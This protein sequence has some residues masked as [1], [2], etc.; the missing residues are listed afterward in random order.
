MAFALGIPFAR[1][2]SSLFPTWLFENHLCTVQNL[3]LG[4]PPT[5]SLPSPPRVEAV[6]PSSQVWGHPLPSGDLCILC[7]LC[8]D[9]SSMHLHM[10]SF[11]QDSAWMPTSPR[12][13]PCP[14]SSFPS[15][16]P[17]TAEALFTGC[18]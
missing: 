12:G 3:A 1:T 6:T 11:I 17:L 2:P 4:L 16:I 13:P 18:L 9:Q 14:P 8:L 15:K 5:G 7:S 10:A